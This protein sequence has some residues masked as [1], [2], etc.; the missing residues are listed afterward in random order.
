MV[1]YGRVLNVHPEDCATALGVVVARALEKA[2]EKGERSLGPEEFGV[3]FRG[4]TSVR[5]D[6]QHFRAMAE[7]LVYSQPTE[8]VDREIIRLY[9]ELRLLRFFDQF[10]TNKKAAALLQ[11]VLDG[12]LSRGSSSVRSRAL[13][14]CARVLY[15]DS[16]REDVSN[17]L[18]VI[19]ACRTHSGEP[20]WKCVM[21]TSGQPRRD[22][23]LAHCT[24]IEGGT[25]GRPHAHCE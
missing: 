19:S 1:K 5:I 7:D 25:I 12:T 11:R 3:V 4:A 23:V 22:S 2:T 8:L 16:E 15:A 20:S 9:E 13:G 10:T 18:D 14:W 24:T 6:N 21:R 17:C